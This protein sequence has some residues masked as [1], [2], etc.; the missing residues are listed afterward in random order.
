LTRYLL[1]TNVISD[2]IRPTPSASLTLWLGSQL[3][4]DLFISA[5]TVAE[6]RRGILEMPRGRKRLLLENWFEG[7]EGPPLLFAGRVLPFDMEAALIWARLMAE[8]S[9]AGRPRSPSDVMISA[10]AISHGLI[11]AT[12]NE[13]HFRGVV[14]F[15][16][17]LR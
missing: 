3:D 6:I 14:E 9:A 10:I 4:E 13:R 16:N 1:D 2:V 15:I 7:P 12:G 17:P 8:G 5:L 11:V